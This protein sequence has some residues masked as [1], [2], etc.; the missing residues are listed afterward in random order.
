MILKIKLESPLALCQLL[1][2]LLISLMNYASLIITNATCF[3]KA[4]ESNPCNNIL[5]GFN[6]R[7]AQGQDEALIDSRYYEMNGFDRSSNILPR[8]THGWR[9]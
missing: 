3:C 2:M 7:G 1:K 9:N 4:A 5:I 6:F 8:K